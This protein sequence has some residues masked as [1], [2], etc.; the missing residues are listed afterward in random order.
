MSLSS[1]IQ[2]IAAGIVAKV[3]GDD[4]HL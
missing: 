1:I 3:P 4:I 2:G